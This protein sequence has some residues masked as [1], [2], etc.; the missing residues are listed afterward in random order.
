[1]VFTLVLLAK[2]SLLFLLY[3]ITYHGL[4]C[5][6]SPVARH[7]RFEGI[8]FERA[9]LTVFRVLGGSLLYESTIFGKA[10]L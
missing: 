7:G 2:E 3:V 5:E 9:I 6:T 1:M 8:F 10:Q 4:S